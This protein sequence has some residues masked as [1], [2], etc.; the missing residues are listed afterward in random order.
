MRNLSLVATILLG[1]MAV[2]INHACA[3]EW[4]GAYVGLYGSKNFVTADYSDPRGGHIAARLTDK[5]ENQFSDFG[6]GIQAGYLQQQ[7]SLVYG[8]EVYGEILKASGCI[9]TNEASAPPTT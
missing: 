2:A 4:S 3:D 5:N 1:G 7:G 6:G 9:N 8:A